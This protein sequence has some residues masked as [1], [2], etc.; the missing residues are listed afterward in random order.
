VDDWP[1][2]RA[3]HRQMY[4]DLLRAYLL[5]Y[6]SQRALATA[7]GF[8]DAYLSL[9]LEPLRSP[10]DGS[11]KL[12]YWAAAA[13]RPPYE[14]AEALRALK[15]PSLD[16]AKQ[17]ADHLCSDEERRE[18]LLYHINQASRSWPSTSRAEKRLSAE[19]AQQVTLSLGAMHHAALHSSDPNA[20]RTGYAQVWESGRAAAALID[21]RRQPLEAARVLMIVHDAACIL[22]RFDLALGYARRAILIL[23]EHPNP[24]ASHEHIRLRTNAALAEA[25][26]L[27]DL[28]LHHEALAVGE[29]AK[30]LPG[31][32][33]EPESWLRSF[34]E[35]R[36]RS[37]ERTRRA[38]IY[39]A[40]RTAEQ[41]RELVADDPILIAGVDTR[42]ADVY[43]AQPSPRSLR[44]AQALVERLVPF[45]QREAGEPPLRRVLA[46]RT[47]AQYFNQT[48][49][50]TMRADLLCRCI[51]IADAAGLA[52]QRAKVEREYGTGNALAIR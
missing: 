43:L 12:A 38:S 15:N 30:T 13:R 51:E 34:L 40:E 41:A 3:L 37:L 50:C 28:G 32:R 44:R 22:N 20:A 49:D 47:A 7:L 4:V 16:R 45:S 17:L 52:H 19:E 14:V 42:L 6:G 23:D 26:A 1:S 18:V 27:N 35:Q 39:D 8:S 10:S 5:Q 29:Q 25:L 11:R 21:E 2:Y 33:V 48:G 36:L 46:L 24:R 9:L 31:Y